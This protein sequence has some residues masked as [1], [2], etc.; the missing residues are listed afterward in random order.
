MYYLIFFIRLFSTLENDVLRRQT[1][2]FDSID[3]LSFSFS[4]L[5][6]SLFLFSFL[7][8]IICFD[9]LALEIS[10]LVL[11]DCFC[12]CCRWN[13]SQ[14]IR[15]CSLPLWTNL[16]TSRLEM[17]L[18]R[19]P[20]VIVKA[21]KSYRKSLEKSSHVTDVSG[22]MEREFLVGM[23]SHFLE[24]VESL[25]QKGAGKR[26]NLSIRLSHSFSFLFF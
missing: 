14:W 8:S 7:F 10:V 6:L 4:L 20:E 23:I 2:R 22:R 25:P 19:S 11:L 21:W 5:S 15:L 24:V 3:P 18:L 12:P 9:L 16:P 1:M 26:S 13:S 17:E